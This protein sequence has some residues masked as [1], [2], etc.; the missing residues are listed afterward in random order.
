MALHGLVRLAAEPVIHTHL[1]GAGT[2]VRCKC[3]SVKLEKKTVLPFWR[4]NAEHAAYR[5][6]SPRC[7]LF[8]DKTEKVFKVYIQY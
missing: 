8:E 6:R 4:P 3:W 2:S 7:T 5:F 1:T